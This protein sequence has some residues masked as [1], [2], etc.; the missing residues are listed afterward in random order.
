VPGILS[1]NSGNFV[2]AIVVSAVA[3]ILGGMILITGVL[4]HT[5]TKIQGGYDAVR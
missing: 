3:V 1:K 2:S 5:M 4:K